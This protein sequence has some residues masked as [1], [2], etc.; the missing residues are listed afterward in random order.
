MNAA[1]NMIPEVI[2]DFNVYEDGTKLIGVSGEVEL[3][4]LESM[5]ETISGAGI[6]GEYETVIPGHF[7][8][9]SMDIPFEM[10]SVPVVKLYSKGSV[11][12]TLRGSQ[13]CRDVATGTVEHKKLR[14]VVTGT[15]TALKFGKVAKT[16]KTAS[17][18]TVQV[19]RYELYIADEEAIVLDKK[20]YVFR[21]FGEDML[22]PIR[23]NI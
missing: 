20:A 14:V 1:I 22:A 8:P 13:Q 6:A 21:V 5:K 3:P 16:K 15:P 12:L 19:L 23:A 10:L 9:I 18:V 11:S 4:T 17:G 2:S 7:S